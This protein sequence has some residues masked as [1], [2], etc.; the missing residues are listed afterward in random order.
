M[1]TSSYEQI[2][3]L[4]ADLL[5]VNPASLSPSSG[6]ETVEAWDSV[7]HLNLVLALEQ[8]FDLQFEPEEIEAMKTLGG[9]AASVDRKLSSS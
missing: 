3:D 7:Q 8:Q 4:A 6:P 2:R 1:S 5:D 9:I